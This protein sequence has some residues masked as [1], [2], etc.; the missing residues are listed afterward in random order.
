MGRTI[1]CTLCGLP[2]KEKDPEITK[3]Q[4][5]SRVWC[6]VAKLEEEVAASERQVLALAVF[7][8]N[9][10]SALLAIRA[11]A[12]QYDTPEWVVVRDCATLALKETE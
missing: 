3:I 12:E 11:V 10:R 1:P 7:G 6:R 5:A 2:I 9:T 8:A 4:H